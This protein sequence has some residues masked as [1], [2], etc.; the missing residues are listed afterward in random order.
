MSRAM[1]SKGGGEATASQSSIPTCLVPPPDPRRRRKAI[2][3]LR[4]LLASHD[5]DSRLSKREHKERVAAL[6][7][8]F[9]RHM[10][11]IYP[12]LRRPHHKGGSSGFVLGKSLQTSANAPFTPTPNPHTHTRLRRGR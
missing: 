10:Q 4:H 3:T 8:H 12:R 1:W 2:G 6:Y 7:I 9:V 11:T 5:M